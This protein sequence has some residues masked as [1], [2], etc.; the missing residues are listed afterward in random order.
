MGCD[1]QCR[2][3]VVENEEEGN[4]AQEKGSMIGTKVSEAKSFF[5]D[6]NPISTLFFS[7]C[8]CSIKER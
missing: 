2:W 1:D 6:E 7:Y 5:D 4:M 8:E 3:S